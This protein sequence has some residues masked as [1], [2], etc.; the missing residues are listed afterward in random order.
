MT[1]SGEKKSEETKEGETYYMAERS[2][3]AFSR[4]VR[5]PYEADEKKTSATF[6]DGVLKLTIPRSLASKTQV[7]KITVQKK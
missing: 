2:Y 5:L 7:H 3:G 6:A 1:I 4:S